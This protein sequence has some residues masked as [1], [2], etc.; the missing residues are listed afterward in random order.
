M[1]AIEL[2]LVTGEAVEQL[3]FFGRIASALGYLVWGASGS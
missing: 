2:P 3:D 1:N